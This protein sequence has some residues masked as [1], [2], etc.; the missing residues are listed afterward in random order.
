[1]EVMVNDG[2]LLVA[3]TRVDWDLGARPAAANLAFP[4]GLILSPIMTVGDSLE[5]VTLLV[6]PSTIVFTKT[7]L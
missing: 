7:S 5:I 4:V 3:P 6:L 1:M 2:L